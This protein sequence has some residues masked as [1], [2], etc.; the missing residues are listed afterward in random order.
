MGNWILGIGKWEHELGSGTWK[1]EVGMGICELE[2]EDLKL[3]I[4]NWKL[5]IGY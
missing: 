2:I 1:G 5:G 3:E 4:G